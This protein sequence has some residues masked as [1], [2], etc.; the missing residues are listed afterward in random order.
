MGLVSAHETTSRK[1]CLFSCPVTFPEPPTI[2]PTDIVVAREFLH[3]KNGS[4]EYLLP[5]FVL[6]YS[7]LH[8]PMRCGRRRD[9]LSSGLAW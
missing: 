4:V 5:C 1:N 7:L 2:I 3:L 8:F 9:L 6:V